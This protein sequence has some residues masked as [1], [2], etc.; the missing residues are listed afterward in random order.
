MV[1]I[2]IVDDDNLKSGFLEQFIRLHGHENFDFR[3]AESYDM[4]MNHIATFYDIVLCDNFLLHNPIPS[5][6]EKFG[7]DFLIEYQERWKDALCFLY[8]AD[9]RRVNTAISKKF[10]CYSFEE[11]QTEILLAIVDFNE[12]KPIK[13]SE[14][15]VEEK[16]GD[17]FNQANCDLKHVFLNENIGEI[18]KKLGTFT[19]AAISTTALVFGIFLTQLFT[20]LQKIHP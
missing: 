4:A 13:K 18:K 8:S 3:T 7:Y 10:K 20:L 9:S 11:V 15:M 1:K 16:K 2:L 17:P 5:E 14:D 6:V 12:R 19:A